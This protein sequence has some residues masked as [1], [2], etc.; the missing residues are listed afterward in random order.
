MRKEPLVSI[1]IN[2][3][4]G[5]EYLE[6]TLHSILNQTY[7]NWE[8]IFFDNSSNDKSKNIF[9]SFDDKRFRY[10]YSKKKINLYDARNK[11]IYKAKGDFISFLDT[12]DIWKRNFLKKHLSIILKFK[13]E[14]V[15]SKYFIKNEEKNK[16]YLKDKNNL[17]SGQITQNLLN[18]YNVGILAV[19]IK[20]SIFNKYKF[21]KKFNLI[22]DFDFFIRVSLKHRFIALNHALSIYRFHKNNF[23]NRNIRIYYL[24]FKQWYK[25]N[26]LLINEFN[27]T[28]LK[29]NF[30]KIRFKYYLKSIF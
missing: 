25:D 12:D 29:Y 6:Q 23:T 14:I 26:F 24:E 1:I 11:A 3:H 22:G 18:N 27:L 7:K 17:I 5:E 9:K 8:I 13:S 2:C 30:F 10:F 21:N 28:K 20:K 19:M 16:T 15:Y 4:N